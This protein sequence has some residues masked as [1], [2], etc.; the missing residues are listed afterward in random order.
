MILS[1]ATT[2][3][4]KAALILFGSLYLQAGLPAAARVLSGPDDR[5]PAR[6]WKRPDRFFAAPPTDGQRLPAVPESPKKKTEQ[7]KYFK[8]ASPSI[9]GPGQPEM[10]SFKSVNSSDMVDLFTGDFSYNIPLMDVGGYPVNIHYSSGISMDQ[11]A[12]WV[13]LGWNINPGTIGRSM[14]GLPDDFN[15]QDTVSKTQNLKEN[16]TIGMKFGGDVEFAGLPVGVGASLG[17]F[18]NTYNGWGIENGINA[19]INVGK[20][21]GPLTASLGLA[22]N[23]NTQ[24]GL[25]IS[26]SMGISLSKK[27]NETDGINVS[28]GLSTNFN[29]R[30]GMSSLNLSGGLSLTREAE[31]KKKES[32]EKEGETVKAK[33]SLSVLN[34]P[35]ASISFSRPSYTPTISVPYTSTNFTFRAKVGGEITGVHPSGFLEGYVSSQKIEKRDQ[36]QALPA[37]GY[38]Y[39]SKSGNQSNALLDF[40]REKELAFN[41]RSTPHIALPQY[42]YDIYSISGEGTGGMFRPYRGD[43]GFARDHSMRTRSNSDRFSIDVGFGNFVHGGVD[44]S[45]TTAFSENGAWNLS[46]DINRF[47]R[48]RESDTT[49]QAVY[50]RNPGERTSNTKAYY[51]S[52][53]DDSL[54][55]VKLNGTKDF[56]SAGAALVT[57][58]NGRPAGE[59][60]I[61]AP[62]VKQQRDKRSQVISYQTAQE[63]AIYGLNKYIKNY[64]DGEIPGL[65]C[66]DSVELIPRFDGRVRKK[67]HLSE[68]TVLGGDGR[69]YVYDV[70]AYNLVQKDVTFSVEKETNAARLAKGLTQYNPGTD[71]STANTKG[72]EGYFAKDSMPAFAH[73]FL[74][75][76][77]LSSDYEDITGDGITDDDLGNAV[78]F[79]YTRAYGGNN[80]FGWRT[81][82]EQN[83]ANYNEGFKTYERDD[84]AT[85]LY[86]TKE[87]WYLN[88]I[89]SRTMVAVFRTVADRK[90]IYS[91]AGENGGFDT[92][93]RLRRLKQIELYTKADLVKNG[94]KARPVKVVHFAYS[95][96]LCK[97]IAG[98][99]S[100]GKLTLD[101]VWFSYNGNNKGRRNPYVFR[102]HAG[103]QAYNPGYNQKH[104]D[105]WGSYKPSGTDAP[106]IQNSD[107]PYAEQ[108]K[109][110][111]D[112]YAAAW[113]MNEI[114]LPS[115]G[116]I[117]IGY[118][119]DDY[120]YVQNKRA[121][122]F[123]K[124]AG[125]GNSPTAVPGTSL[126]NGVTDFYYAFVNSDMTL[127]G[128]VEIRERYLQGIDYLYFKMSVL[129]PARGP[130]KR[131]FV[132]TYAEI[133][134][135]GMVPGNNKRFWI[136]LKPV[137]GESPLARGALQFLRLNLPSLAYPGSEPGDD[138][139]LIDAV[140]M[141]GSSGN[142]MSN[143]ILGYGRA[144][145]QKGF[146][147]I[148]DTTASFIRLN[149][150]T[151]RKLGGGLRVKRVEIRDNW[152]QMTGMKQA[153]YGQE[154]RY[155][156]PAVI[157]GDTVEA[158]SGVASYEPMIGAEENPF[159]TPVPY[160][161]KTA[162][163][164]PANFL[165][166][167]NPIGES[168]FPGAGVGYSRVVVRTINAKL[169]SA[170]GWQET[171]FFTTRDFPTIVEHS[172]LDER[173][174]KTHN[175][176]LANFLRINATN[177]VT[178]SQ[179]FKIELNDMNGKVRRQASY[180]ETDSL[181]PISYSLNFYKVD[182]E[183]SPN[184]RLN[185]TVWVVDSLNGNIRPDGIVGK[186]IEVIQDMR[187]QESS[188]IAN[189]HSV[190][191]DAAFVPFLISF[192]SSFSLPQKELNRFRSAATVKIIQRYGI[193]DSVVV[194][195]KGSVVS[196]KNL[197]YDA[198]TG[199]V[200]LSRTN[201]EF[202]DPI[203][204]FSYPAH[205]AYSG[206][207]MAYRN[208]DAIF[209]GLKL[210]K[211]KLYYGG[212]STVPYPVERFFESGDEVQIEGLERTVGTGGDCFQ[213]SVPALGL[214]QPKVP[215]P[216]KAWVID[217]AKSTNPEEGLYFIDLNG[218][219]ITG[220]VNYMRILRSGR[221]NLLSASVGSIVAMANPIRETGNGGYKIVIDSNTRIINTSAVTYRDTWQIER[222]RYLYDS[223]YI[224]SRSR[225]E[226]LY[227]TN[228]LLTFKKK[229]IGDDPMEQ[230]QIKNPDRISASFDDIAKAGDFDGFDYRT[231]TVL[232]FDFASLPHYET[233]T[234]ISNAQFLAVG[235]RPG[236]IWPYQTEKYKCGLFNTCTA[237][238]HNWANELNPLGGN[239]LTRLK[240]IQAPWNENT[241]YLD[242]V[243]NP[244]NAA[245]MSSVT[246]NQQ[247]SYNCTSLVNDVLVNKLPYYG[248][249][250]QLNTEVDQNNEPNFMSF[251]G[252]AASEMM[253][254]AIRVS[255]TYLKDT[256][257]SVCRYTDSLVNPYRWGIAGNWRTDRAY[258][259]YHDR[260]ESDASSAATDI[261]KEGEL[262]NFTPFWKFSNA[263]LRVDADTTKWV[264]NSASSLFNKKGLEMENYDP[265]GR[266]NAGLYGYNNT[267]PIAVAQN[268]RYREILYDGFE[269]Y[270]YSA[271]NCL[272]CPT[273]RQIDF[274]NGQTGV[275][276]V[277]T[278]SHTGNY[279]LKI[280]AGAT[281]QFTA[282]AG[283]T[284]S[285]LAGMVV[286]A[287]S[288]VVAGTII[289]GGGGKLTYLYAGQ[290]N[291]TPCPVM[292]A[293]NFEGGGFGYV[294]N[295]P[296]N[297]DW[298]NTAPYPG[299]CKD[300]FTIQWYGIIQAPYTD[301]YRFHALSSLGMQVIVNGVPVVDALN[302]NVES[303]GPAILLQKGKRNY[304]RIKYQ[305]GNGA[306]RFARLRWSRTAAP[307]PVVI[308]GSFFYDD[309]KTFIND[310]GF[311]Y[312]ELPCINLNDIKS[313]N[314]QIKA[315]S[316]LKGSKMVVSAWV[317]M[318]GDDCL[319]APALDN[320]LV[321]NQPG[322][323]P[324]NTTLL[325]TG[326]RIEG[327]QRY[328]AV[329][330]VPSNASSFRLRAVAPGN[331]AIYLDDIRVHPYNSAMKSY[332]YDAAS[333]RLMAELD[334]NNYAS[335][336]EYDDDGTL[337]RVKKETERGIMTI[338]ESRSALLK[339]Q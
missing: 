326:V 26:P 287:D 284:E 223:C 254:P 125:I 148:I 268:S 38:L 71:N 314:N 226:T 62:I 66:A 166:S 136:K 288:S 249:M 51:R 242:F 140:Q 127:S 255:Y 208:I 186:D 337:V 28:M 69:R 270:S 25:D 306:E 209:K 307:E 214:L 44:Y 324:E 74:L 85:Y 147:K 336:Y 248:F 175:P 279:S 149:N 139:D 151:L 37:F 222:S 88:S 289:N 216:A 177:L 29:S 162:P 181:R 98:D 253:P 261:R 24:T 105:R 302:P 58:S 308:P 47:L 121:Q 131:E 331:R 78:K 191:F 122:Q 188:S 33:G 174:K 169:K 267:L 264:W 192:P 21:V 90:D 257:V 4:K 123:F 150:P 201:N 276:T 246:L 156:T 258:T 130:N 283:L 271:R 128:K 59:I 45:V 53:G 210:I 113:T 195:D 285:S 12:S 52:I 176:R 114:Q 202:R 164:A 42:T 173:S 328:E 133:E 180:A 13:G 15:G 245:S 6:S 102:Y 111:A 205:W 16:R 263:V 252:K 293:G 54:I 134:D 22:L 309:D 194:M 281:A 65:G 272:P 109:A 153:V 11:E 18:H 110:K 165:F 243:T 159:R 35:S 334:E 103:Q 269:D 100:M 322:T 129:V 145:R 313:N 303:S 317:K 161:E 295:M 55:R 80:G 233:I 228:T 72:K 170:N 325:R 63:A 230:K 135:Y 9:G 238:N 182:N 286:N 211:G 124:L 312:Q 318:D 224:V 115:G 300:W 178:V 204:N 213:F 84:K 132:P 215:V 95:Y 152:N 34:F 319:T 229:A 107:Y 106:F 101:S 236:T 86:G 82:G 41:P 206:M 77:I 1:L 321:V 275:D 237:H 225:T 20:V 294:E 108:N 157:N 141:I 36:V 244:A 48:F 118:E 57:Y 259:F 93:K 138:I 155:T 282:N 143:A 64:R 277:T 200:V 315:F 32:S 212:N 219:P 190:N 290:P 137:S 310:S 323:F 316:P 234:A 185:N 30:A 87:V 10:S 251:Y 299:I 60:P 179:G 14:R 146:C 232:D 168:F 56:V 50:F 160:V 291:A 327:W 116:K 278:Q 79:N 67:H 198:E 339:N 256:C 83:M 43:V 94:N 193:L 61:T 8:A 217:A 17:L 70:P 171:Q 292:P 301:Y 239:S 273:P 89:E 184:K 262:K 158:S 142:E 207:G 46:N 92:S 296:L 73:S 227:S 332:V 235:S 117:N 297:F 241:K 199:E 221:R 39:Y 154:Y 189:N 311:T 304:I 76:G 2:H 250:M 75:G 5:L 3:R 112:V 49:Y 144:A 335:F 68:I 183:L 31:V 97:G 329:V 187:Q 274:R 298:G 27:M 81:P 40:N 163:S 320:V 7:R 266:Y 119:S 120:G 104:N 126:Y 247:S 330:T 240:R 167:E 99:P 196:T 218:K 231:K 91:V 265:L 203:Y 305:H 333:L 338:K 220:E 172:L 280:A 260:K 197:V 23:N 96:S 19:S